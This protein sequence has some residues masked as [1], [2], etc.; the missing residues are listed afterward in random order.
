MREII[1]R[2]KRIDNNEWVYGYLQQED[3]INLYYVKKETIGQFTGITDINGNKIFEGDFL[4]FPF[5]FGEAYV[6]Y[7]G[8]RFAVKSEGS[9]AIDYESS[10]VLQQCE[11]IGNV[12]NC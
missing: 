3:K 8:I 11:I 1:F 2:G 10:E 9:E 7:D 6:I 12:Y 4:K 5:D